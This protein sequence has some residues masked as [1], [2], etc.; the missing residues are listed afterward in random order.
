MT[1]A[2]HPETVV[3]T[4]GTSGIGLATARALTAR[5][6][7]VVLAVRD[8]GK[9]DRVARTLADLD[10]ADDVRANH[11]AEAAQYRHAVGAR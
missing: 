8:P 2:D 10:A 4:G 9:G 7:H 6:D 3:L 5:G 1:S 11:I